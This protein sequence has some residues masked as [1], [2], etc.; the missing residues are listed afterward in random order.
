MAA[1]LR[2]GLTS[3]QLRQMA[4]VLAT[5]FDAD[6]GKRA[7]DALAHALAAMEGKD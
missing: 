1:S 7:N 6:A 4:D 3:A 5:R 2:V